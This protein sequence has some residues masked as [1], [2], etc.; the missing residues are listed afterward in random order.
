VGWWDAYRPIISLIRADDGK[1]AAGIGSYIV[2][3]QDGWFLTAAH[4]MALAH[5][6]QVDA[7]SKQ[8][9]GQ[10]VDRIESD[11]NLS[12]KVKRRM[13]RELARNDKWIANFSFVF[14]G[15]AAQI[16]GQANVDPAADIAVARLDTLAGLNISGFPK[17]PATGTQLSPGTSLCTLGF[18]FQPL[19]ATFD[20]TARQFNLPAQ[21]IAF[22]PSEGIHT[23]YVNMV[24][25][26]SNPNRTIPYIETS[27]PDSRGRAAAQS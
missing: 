12:H 3:N 7:I 8:N 24:D 20:S 10:A 9:Y 22:F 15:S 14:A 2:L 18:P 21:Q 27:S 6:A 13:V 1:V 25:Q 11:P 5:Q 4:I 17:F 16:L 23:R 19:A 26:T